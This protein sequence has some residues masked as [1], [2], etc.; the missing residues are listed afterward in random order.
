[1]VDAETERALCVCVCVCLQAQVTLADSA[2]YAFRNCDGCQYSVCL[3]GEESRTFSWIV[4]P[5]TLGKLAVPP[6][7]SYTSY[8]DANNANINGGMKLLYFVFVP[9]PVLIFCGFN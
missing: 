8:R 1:M 5:S 2:Q 6:L 3:C 9:L 4:T 7:F